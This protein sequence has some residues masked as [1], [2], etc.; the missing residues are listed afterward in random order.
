[1]KEKLHLIKA[2]ND[3]TVCSSIQ[4]SKFSSNISEKDALLAMPSLEHVKTVM[5]L[6]PNGTC[7]AESCDAR[8][9]LWTPFRKTALNQWIYFNV[10]YTMADIDIL[11]EKMQYNLFQTNTGDFLSR[12]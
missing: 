8:L 2:L 5:N 12:E 4:R 7:I 6:L 10:T 3:A 1:M 9:H 11:V